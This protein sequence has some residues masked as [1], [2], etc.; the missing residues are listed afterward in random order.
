MAL[1]AGDAPS[2]LR[3]PALNTAGVLASEQGDFAA[4]R[5]LFEETVASARSAG[6]LGRAA[7]ASSNL[8]ILALYEGDFPEAIRRYGEAAE[9][10]R[11]EGDVRWLS[12]VTQNLGVAHSLGGDNDRAVAL[13]E[14]SVALAREAGDPAHLAST[15]R[16]LARALLLAGREPPDAL[17]PL[18]EGLALSV[19]LDERPGIAECLETLAGVVEPRMGAELI[20][21]AEAARAAAGATRQPDEEAWV[22]D[23]TA[24]LRGSLGEAFGQAVQAGRV[25]SL[26]DAVARAVSAPLIG[27]S[28]D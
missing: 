4:A 20:G 27:V 10:W 19:E 26:T 3:L 17:E 2:E 11:E 28:T 21:A 12:V 13:L 14:E 8:G 23:V 7:R 5:G 9:H 16:S 22:A 18:R 1:A 25:V 24:A 6:A 15:L